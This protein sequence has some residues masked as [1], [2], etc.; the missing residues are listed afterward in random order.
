MTKKNKAKLIQPSK[1]KT[2]PP[3]TR[4]KDRKTTKSS[5]KE[6]L[7]TKK[8]LTSA[9]IKK[10]SLK[11]S[12]LAL[13]LFLC[14][15]ATGVILFIIL[16]QFSRKDILLAPPTPHQLSTITNEE[17]FLTIKNSLLQ[18][19][20]ET[21][22]NDD[23]CM[24]ADFFH[25]SFKKTAYAHNK[26]LVILKRG[27][28]F[29]TN[30]TN[31]K[32]ISYTEISPYP[33]K[34]NNAIT[35]NNIFI[36]NSTII[37]TG[38]R[39]E[40]NSLEITTFPISLYGK[41]TRGE[42][43]SLPSSACNFASNFTNGEL[44]FYTSRKLSTQTTLEDIK[45]INQWSIKLNEFIVTHPEDNNIFY[46]NATFLA[47]PL[48]HTITTCQLQEH[49][50]INCRQ[51]HLIDNPSSGHY[52]DNDNFYLWTTQLPKNN[53]PGRIIPSAKLHQFNLSTPVIQ[54]IQVEGIP[55]SKDAISLNN[56]QLSAII[57]QNNSHPP[58]WHTNFTSSKIANFKI[59]SNEFSKEGGFINSPDNYTL[60][61]NIFDN[62]QN[63]SE[64]I[65][66]TNPKFITLNQ[67]TSTVTMHSESKQS[68]SI[69]GDILSIQKLPN[70]ENLL[71]IYKKD[72][73]IV[74]RTVDTHT[75]SISIP[76]I[77]QENISTTPLS[78]MSFVTI[79][80]QLFASITLLEESSNKGY[81]HLL[82]ISND[83]LTESDSLIFT[84][85]YQRVTDSC[86]NDCQQSWQS[87]AKYFTPSI[88]PE[89]NKNNF[90]YATAGSK[91]R[92]LTVSDVGIVRL[93]N[94]IDY[95]YL[96]LTPRQ[97]ALRIARKP[98]SAKR[99]NGKYV[100]KKKEKDEFIGKSKKNNKGY[101]HL[102][103]ECCLDPDE[104]PNPWC[105]YRPGELSRTKYTYSDY[106]Y[107]GKRIH[108]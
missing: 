42:T 10:P 93:F 46:D 12:F 50:L 30:T 62:L 28:L 34:E 79:Q 52:L 55:I 18:N 51:R 36:N 47:R 58:A 80:N 5:P 59:N 22:S 32:F 91:L 68:F 60:T 89:N 74:A 14:I 70:K 11:T 4:T 75:T 24:E 64:E 56:N 20:V 33:V 98:V 88:L 7:V 13:V 3:L 21:P 15:I 1:D 108:K 83:E 96:P 2:K 99:V 92:K 8:S 97:K 105:S 45:K 48:I 53:T 86:Q 81:L 101:I 44:I 95:T 35:Y 23:N 77:L 94:T 84:K 106:T 100:C 102:D 73:S 107:A 41:I 49:S 39:I 63:N 6:K 29:V 87:Q 9:K 17:T 37:V 19:S 31:N 54:M 90:I 57:Y 65:I 43:Y 71:I 38:Y 25:T 61:S 69:D 66:E 72:D 40:T 26:F 82:N 27:K 104:F 103:L 67:I 85:A 78:E 76:L 16:S